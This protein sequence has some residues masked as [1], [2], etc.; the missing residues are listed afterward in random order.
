MN[1][2]LQDVYSHFNDPCFL[3]FIMRL[4]TKYFNE[5]T[6]TICS[7]C[8]HRTPVLSSFMT[9]HRICNKSNTTGATREAGTAYLFRNTQ[10]HPRF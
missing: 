10:A 4:K 9:N 3:R 2:K 6:L 1:F 7:V 5:T 8:C